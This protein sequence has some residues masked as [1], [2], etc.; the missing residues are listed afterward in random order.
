MLKAT[1]FLTFD[2]CRRISFIVCV[3]GVMCVKLYAGFFGD[4]AARLQDV[5]L[6]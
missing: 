1:L 3:G 2:M 4:S 5:D 6:P